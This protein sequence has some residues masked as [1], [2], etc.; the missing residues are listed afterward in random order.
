M[1]LAMQTMNRS[2][3]NKRRDAEYLLKID[4][5]NCKASE[6]TDPFASSFKGKKTKKKHNNHP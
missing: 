5:I 3:H 4:L 6:G 1:P 2:F